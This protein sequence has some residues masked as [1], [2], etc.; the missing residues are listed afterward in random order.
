[1]IMI[2]KKISDHFNGYEFKCPHCGLIKIDEN[3]IEKVEHI[4]NKLNA[5]KCIV[6]SGYRCPNY[7]VFENGFAGRH[8]EGLAMDCCFYDKNNKII[9][10]K[11]VICVAF[12]LHELNGIAKIDNNYVHLD[13]RKNSVYHGDETKGNSNYWNNPYNYFNVSKSE[14][15]K[16][17]P[18]YKQIFYQVHSIEDKKYYSNVR[19]NTTD[20]AGVFGK[21]IDGVLI[22]DLEYRVRVKGLIFN[23]WLKPVIG[24]TDY[25]GYL[26]HRITGIAIKN[27]RYRV[28]IKN[29][30]WL[31]AVSGYNINDPKY[32]Y[33]GNGKEIDG[34]QI[35][36]I[37]L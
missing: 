6:S 2:D 17:I 10:S 12:D 27:A 24:R 19:S 32:G 11:I 22:D 7:D 18:N 15:D 1:M 20:Y 29:S 31:P 35:I 30:N 37:M 13:N 14:V 25:A 16:Y 23:R 26:D 5:S 4:F 33:A 8:S 34:L 28:H 3:L 36:E 9:P 21:T